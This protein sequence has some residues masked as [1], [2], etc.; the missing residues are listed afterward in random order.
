MDGL[1]ATEDSL[2]ILLID[3]SAWWSC[4]S[5]DRSDDCDGEEGAVVLLLFSYPTISLN[6][7]VGKEVL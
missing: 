6:S 5:T 1:K 3:C 4:E 2:F 7:G